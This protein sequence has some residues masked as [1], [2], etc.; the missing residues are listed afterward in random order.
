MGETFYNKDMYLLFYFGEEMNREQYLEDAVI[1]QGTRR[2][3]V[4]FGSLGH[5]VFYGKGGDDVFYVRMREDQIIEEAGEGN[6]TVVSSVTYTAPT[7]VENL[8]LVGTDNIFGFGNNSDNILTGNSGNNRLSGGRGKD[9]LYGMAGN[10]LLLGG[11]GNDWLDGGSGNDILRGDAGS[12]T[13]YGGDGNDRLE[14]GAGADRMNGGNGNDVYIVDDAGDVIIET[15][16]GGMDTVES[17]VSHTLATH[18]ENLILTG[19]ANIYGAGN[20]SD[21]VLTGNGGYNRLNAGR[22]NDV[23]YGM[24][25]ED[26]LNGG[27]GHDRLYGGEGKD[28]LNGDEGDDQL[29]GEAGN[30]RLNG[31]AGHDLLDGGEGDDALNGGSGNDVY[32]FG[33][34]YGRD[35]ITDSDG[36]NIVR[37]GAGIRVQDLQIAI[38][39]NAWVLSLNGTNDS[40][41]VNIPSGQTISDI[42]A[43]FEFSD[44]QSFTPHKLL[45]ESVLVP[46]ENEQLTRIAFKEGQTAVIVSEKGVEIP[47]ASLKYSE[48]KSASL[49]YPLTQAEIAVAEKVI[50]NN[51]GVS[52]KAV[53]AAFK[54]T[55]GDGLIDAADSHPHYWN[56]SDRDLRM[57]ATVA[58]AT[59]DKGSLQ[60]AFS[61]RYGS[62]L[63]IDSVK[64]DFNGQVDISEYQGRWDVVEVVSKGEWL[65]SGLD[66]T[67]FG[68]GR[69]WDGSYENVVVAFRGT[70]AL[71]DATAG[72]K[73]AQGDTPTQAKE[74]D[75]IITKLAQY[76]PDHIFSTGHSLG[77]YLAQYFAAYTVQNSMFKDEFVRSVL[78]NTA[79]I[80]ADSSST[81][82][83]HTALAR[84]EQFSQERIYDAKF[85]HQSNPT[86]KTNSYVINGEWLSSGDVPTRYQAVAAV[87]AGAADAVKT[88]AKGGFLGAL[89]GLAATIATGGAAAPLIWTGA[90]AGAAVGGAVGV[91]KGTGTVLDFD[92]LGVYKNTIFLN[93]TATNQNGWD[94]H[95]LAN[96]YETSTEI[97]KYFSQGYRVDNQLAQNHKAEDSDSDGLTDYQ[98][99]LIG[100]NPNR[101]DSDGDGVSDGVE[102]ELGY[103][104]HSDVD[105]THPP[106]LTA[107]VETR[108]AQGNVISVKGVEMPSEIGQNEI[109]YEPSGYE[110]KLEADAFDWSAFENQPAAQ[111][112]T[113]IE[114][115]QGNDVIVGTR[116]NDV[117]WGGLGSDTIIGSQGRDI[118]VFKAV[119]VKSGAVDT[120]SDFN[121]RE[122]KLDLT[123]LRPLWN[124]GGKVL[125]LSD[126]LDND[127]RLFD[128]PHLS[129][130]NAAGT[131]AY[132]AS[133][134]DAGTVFLKMDDDQIGA[135]NAGNVLV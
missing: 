27:E 110:R 17:S 107:I 21:N 84:S 125:K 102:A 120:L 16:Y 10:D 113:V 132:K 51:G 52:N 62:N 14:G 76:N 34:G 64:A 70:K 79:K 99:L 92:G 66:Y 58:Y 59:E 101:A 49:R 131:L 85:A 41:T 105:V 122:D 33:K 40:L 103:N 22:G 54:D 82:D 124:G 60:R 43:Q 117:I 37:L 23:I 2:N 88:A 97:Q 104:V 45:A 44:G 133:A 7:H 4:L 47:T 35:T 71:Q 93:N 8:T 127:E 130:D 109:V 20:N 73:L 77:G 11:D 36:F 118:F 39:G 26:T 61:G 126:L 128:Y 135:L 116:G 119:D 68:N 80:T 129:V 87:A 19:S 25:G 30:D 69:K 75:E 98:E 72:L 15:A 96:F 121:A 53:Q 48:A 31:G 32:L 18:V 24:G 65:G 50:A 3:D 89:F 38:K 13:L 91:V 42:I 95:V 63:T 46:S 28:L 74:M 114:G 1:V 12:D 81:S 56:V 94:K 108:D 55:D 134:D 57:F 115:T 9:T 111:G 78:F 100:T 67:I 86:Y 112:V 29:Y 83:L 123:G 90:K 106:T 6:D 5:T